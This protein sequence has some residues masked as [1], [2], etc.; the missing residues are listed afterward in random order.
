MTGR[1]DPSHSG[2]VAGD[3]PHDCGKCIGA[4]AVLH[5]FPMLDGGAATAWHFYTLLQDQQRMGGMGEAMGLDYNVLPF[6]FDTYGVAPAPS[7]ERQKL[8][9]HIVTINHTVNAHRAAQRELEAARA[10]AKA[11]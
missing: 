7:R 4:H 1:Q 2:F 10:K 11:H 9:G 3:Q 8:V 5:G 6:F